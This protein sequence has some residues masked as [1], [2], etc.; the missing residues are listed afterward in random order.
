MP[1][2]TF[3]NLGNIR[4]LNLG[5]L[6]LN[7]LPFLLPGVAARVILRVQ[8]SNLALSHLL[9]IDTVKEDSAIGV[10]LFF[11]MSRVSFRE[12]LYVE[13]C[14]VK[15]SMWVSVSQIGAIVFHDD[16]RAYDFHFKFRF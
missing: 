11:Y 10:N 13:S 12:D 8:Q 6:A 1:P 16:C 7:L 2:F 3:L 9:D 5:I 4:F 15:G 14:L